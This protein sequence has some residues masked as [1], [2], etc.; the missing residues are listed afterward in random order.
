MK[1]SFLVKVS[2]LVMMVL[3]SALYSKFI[4][5]TL[6]PSKD[7]IGNF[8]ILEKVVAAKS[9]RKYRSLWEKETVGKNLARGKTFVSSV[10]PKY[11]FTKPN[12]LSL[13]TDGSLA[14]GLAGIIDK[15]WVSPQTVGWAYD[16]RVQKGLNLFID[17]K[18]SKPIGKIVLR[19]L[20]GKPQ[21]TIAFPRKITVSLSEDGVNYFDG[22][23]VENFLEGDLHAETDSSISLEEKGKYYVYPF[24]IK[25]IDIKARY[26][27][28]TV[29]GRTHLLCIDEIA[30]MESENPN[31]KDQKSLKRSAFVT[32]G[33]IIEPN[34]N[35]LY[36]SEN[37]ITPQMFTLKDYRKN[38]K[39]PV[40][41]YIELPNF[42]K[43]EKHGLLADAS[44][45]KEAFV[46]TK[47]GIKTPYT[48]WGIH[49][50]KPD[51]VMKEKLIFGPLWIS[52]NKAVPISKTESL[53]STYVV[54][55]GKKGTKISVPVEVIT[56][57]KVPT[58]NYF[59]I[60]L[61]WIRD[62]DQQIWPGYVNAMAHMGFN[63]IPVTPHWWKEG[64]IYDFYLEASKRKDMKIVMI[65]S[66][67]HRM[68]T[69]RSGESEI[70]S[71]YEKGIS[72]KH[73]CP[74]YRGEFFQEELKRVVA[75]YEKSKPDYVIFDIEIYHNFKKD[76]PHCVRCQK[77]FRAS[78]LSEEQF[79]FGL[80][81]EIQ[82]A[83][84]D[85]IYKKAYEKGWRPPSIGLYNV[86]HKADQSSYMDV[87][88]APTLLK[89]KLIDFTMPELYIRGDSFLTKD[90]LTEDY[91]NM[92]KRKSL[93]WL[94][95]GTYGEYP[96][97]DI[98][99]M[100]YASFLNGISGLGYFSYFDFQSPIKFY[101]HAKA[102]KT[103][104]PFE[105]LLW[106]GKPIQ[107]KGTKSEKVRVSAWGKNNELLIFVDNPRISKMD[108]FKLSVPMKE[109]TK[110]TDVD[111]GKTLSKRELQAYS[112]SGKRFGLIHVKGN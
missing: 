16:S 66:P 91:E 47:N 45:K 64:K 93:P 19:I 112:I 29:Y 34:Q 87:F 105:K 37:I 17:L 43:L 60:S 95:T 32:S 20:G 108:D 56:I 39:T 74:C 70:Y 81:N 15:I 67:I 104:A 13:L 51:Y 86:F 44:L 25:N 72:S 107:L 59:L 28:I 42:L 94:T 7:D 100:L 27:G 14:L 75:N 85:A 26:V 30:I 62:V 92:Q 5:A 76:F 24:T 103:L 50:L 83:I 40:S 8:R 101:Y 23:G 38:T 109:I 22:G 73:V 78:K 6:Q 54:N 84:R 57:P 65:D 35:K 102:L 111:L 69:K 2:F 12:D 49:G 77:K 11:K 53:M 79:K 31:I 52:R 10:E 63:L 80:G 99:P 61:A 58:Y 97:E 55:D 88:N 4:A 71:Q 9:A 3:S 90:L 96:P 48:R 46:V 41:Y 82:K 68:A 18:E 1:K 36:V 33:V 98:E 21:A 89:E 110:I 106:N